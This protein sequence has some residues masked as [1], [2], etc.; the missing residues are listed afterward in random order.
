MTPEAQ[1]VSLH[2]WTLPLRSVPSAVVA[3]RG[4]ARRERRHSP[5]G[6]VKLLGTSQVGRFGPRDGNLRRWAVLSC[7]QPASAAIAPFAARALESWRVDLTPLSSIGRWSK[8]EPF[9]AS[10]PRAEGGRL[11]VI[12]RATL[13]PAKA[14]TFWRAVPDVAQELAAADGVRIAFGIGEAPIGL[15]GTFSVWDDAEAI[16]RFAYASP[17]HSAAVAD[18]TRIGWYGEQLFARFAVLASEGTIDGRDPAA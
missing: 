8:R 7:G 1:V 17:R 3:A 15:Q 2:V 18:T 11:A 12:T 5:A 16:R 14:T 13:R 6:F 4:R 10:T 9:V